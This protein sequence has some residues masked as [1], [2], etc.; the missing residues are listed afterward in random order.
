M[1]HNVT[2]L[3]Q[4][5]LCSLNLGKINIYMEER[6]CKDFY[7]KIQLKLGDYLSPP[8]EFIDKWETNADETKGEEPTMPKFYGLESYNKYISSEVFL[9]QDGKHMRSA[10]V[11]NHSKDD[12]GK[13]IGVKNDNPIVDTYVYNV[14]FTYGLLKQY[15]AIVI[16]DNM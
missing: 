9:N 14:M 6:K 13:L 12:K 10:K 1:N 3:P 11:F 16:D 7:V 2:V 5:K 4:Q 8:K 15:E